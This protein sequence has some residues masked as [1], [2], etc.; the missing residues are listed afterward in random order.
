MVMGSTR[1]LLVLLALVTVL[2]LGAG[3]AAR[4]SRGEPAHG[5]AAGLVSCIQALLQPQVGTVPAAGFAIR[6][7]LAPASPAAP[8]VFPRHR[9]QA[10]PAG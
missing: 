6:A 7:E 5:P 3:A 10:P 2:V 8:P 1:A 4:A 9:S